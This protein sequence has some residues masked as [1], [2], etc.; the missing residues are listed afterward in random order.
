MNRKIT[1]ILLKIAIALKKSGWRL[2]PDYEVELKSEGH[3]SLKKPIRVQGALGDEEWDDAIATF[4]YL[5]L[6]SDDGITYY[7]EY[8]VNAEIFIQGGDIK[9]VNYKMDADIGLMDTDIEDER[10]IEL[11]AR[12][13]NSYVESHIESEYQSYLDTN[14]DSIKDYKAGGW[15]ADDEDN[16]S[17]RR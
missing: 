15:K 1:A 11:A 2:G 8:V 13:I 14:A 3:L 5:R 12:K 4:M 7:P 16:F 10:K 17:H 9:D 6:D